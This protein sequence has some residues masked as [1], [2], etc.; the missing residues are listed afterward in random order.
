MMKNLRRARLI[1]L[2][3][4][5]VLISA[6]VLIAVGRKR[7][8]PAGQSPAIESNQNSLNAQGPDVGIGGLD[9]YLPAGATISDLN[10]FVIAADLD[11]DGQK[12]QIIFYNVSSQSKDGI[13]VLKR[14]AQEYEKIWETSYDDSS[15]FYDQSSVYN[16]NNS[17]RPQIVSYRAIGA[18]C[19]GALEIYE[20]R[21]ARIERITGPWANSDKLCGSIE[22]KDLKGDGR[23][24]IIHS[25]DHG[26]NPDIYKWNGK[27]YV[28]SNREF[29]Q[30]Y[31]DAVVQIVRDTYSITQL[32][33]S[34]RVRSCK[35]AVEIYLS[36]R[37][38]AEA[39]ALCNGVLRILDDPKLT[40]PNSILSD[41]DKPEV[42]QRIMAAFE[43]ERTEGK[44]QVLRLLGDSYKTAGNPQQAKENY[45]AAKKL[46]EQAKELSAKLGTR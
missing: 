46:E 19:L 5:I 42:R 22:I 29:P 34:A 36:E 1:H 11:A 21:N 24:E 45:S 28:Q 33:T 3:I 23:R 41:N 30:Y 44:A 37:R 15:S 7:S 14:K 39:I 12:E 38:P 25:Q 10:K 20:Y 35:Q 27:E 31:E 18:S 16:L 43:I 9:R 17:N 4:V 40:I 8:H 13:V 2:A 32:P 26:R 6:L